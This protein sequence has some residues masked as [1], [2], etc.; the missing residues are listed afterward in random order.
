MQYRCVIAD[1]HPAII[2]AVARYLADVDD[3]EIVGQAEGGDEALRLIAEHAPD[4]AIVDIRMPG[5]GGIDIARKLSDE[6]SKTAV[7]LYTGHGERSLLLEALDAGA[8]GFL[9][10]E[11]PLDDLA[12]AI[13]TIGGGGTYVDPALAGVLAGPQAAERLPD[14]D[15]ART[16]DPPAPRR[17]DAQRGGRSATFDLAADRPDACQERDAEARGGH[18]HRGGC[19]SPP[20]LADRLASQS[21]ILQKEDPAARESPIAAEGKADDAKSMADLR[22]GRQRQAL[23]CVLADDH[24]ELLAACE[25]LLE[26]EG[27]RVL[28][29]AKTGEGA[30]QILEEQPM[31]AV[32]V[33]LRLPDLNGLE[34]ARRVSEIAR[35]KTAVII[36]TSYADDKMVGEALDAGARAV[37]LK[38]GS[39]DNLLTAMAAVAAG[40]IFV[41]PQ[42][43]SNTAETPS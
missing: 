19:E 17:R 2:D 25:S 37:V 27:V 3:V 33:D 38:D 35:R 21:S 8:R 31:T 18:P 12:R 34:V 28:G 29:K 23:A 7:I 9:V 14:R 41:D 30:L 5:V 13:R 42:L 15:Q 26:N 10:K 39:C 6:G 40:E 43:R 24:D 20:R 32:V 22:T 36:Y 16:G 11:A 1:D 4:V